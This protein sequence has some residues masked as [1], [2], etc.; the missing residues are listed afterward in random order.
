M[1]EKKNKSYFNTGVV[2]V[3][4]QGNFIPDDPEIDPDGINAL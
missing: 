3:D 2:F 4:E 1:D